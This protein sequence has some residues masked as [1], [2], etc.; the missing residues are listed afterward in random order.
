MRPHRVYSLAE[1]VGVAAVVPARPA[2]GVVAIAGLLAGLVV[3]AIVWMALTRADMVVRAPG[4]VRG[5][6]SHQVAFSAAGSER[7]VASVGGRVARLLVHE[8]ERVEVGTPIVQLDATELLAEHTRLVTQLVDAIAAREGGARMSSLI[9]AEHEAAQAAREAELGQ[10]IRDESRGRARRTSE[11]ALASTNLAARQRELRRLEAMGR[12]GAASAA[13]IE[14]ALAGVKEATLRVDAAR[15]AASS[16]SA[17]VLRRQIELAARVYAIRQ[18]ELAQQLAVLEA[19]VGA[20]RHAVAASVQELGRRRIV[21]Q[22]SGVVSTLTVAVG[23]VVQ[24]GQPLVTLAPEGGLRV[25]AAVA[26]TDVA[27]L[28]LGMTVRI[29]LDAFDWQRFGTVRGTLVAISPDAEPLGP[30]QPLAYTV[31]IALASDLVGSG[32][33]TGRLKLGMTGVVEIV[34]GRERLLELVVG[35]MRSAISIGE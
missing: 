27:R 21:A 1:C 25:D 11:I 28:Q 31:R 30:G 15:V 26:I 5:A 20:A 2:S 34:T 16:G 6:H 12:D 35:R 14:E 7:V 29:R 3:G 23:D 19:A 18:E 17:T 32:D 4:R 33:V 10:V 13:S 9:G 8:G 24:P 22:A